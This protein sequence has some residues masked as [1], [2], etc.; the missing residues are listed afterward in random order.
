MWAHA[1]PLVFYDT[2]SYGATAVGAVEGL[3][4]PQQLL[5]GSDRPVLEPR[6]RA[7]LDWDPIAEGTGRALGAS[8]PAAVR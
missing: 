5:Y 3:V 7:E 8:S 2:S 1:D 4:E 6:L